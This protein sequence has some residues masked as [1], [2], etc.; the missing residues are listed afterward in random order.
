MKHP[1]T[2]KF[3]LIVVPDFKKATHLCQVI[4]KNGSKLKPIMVIEN[5]NRT[6]FPERDGRTDWDQIR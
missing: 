1:P 3:L 2:A 4:S 6:V 5:L